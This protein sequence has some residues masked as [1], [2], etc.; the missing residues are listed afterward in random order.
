MKF[1]T[2]RIL[3]PLSFLLILS[4]TAFSQTYNKDLARESAF[5]DSITGAKITR[6]DI[7]P[8]A[9]KLKMT[10][11]V[12]AFTLALWQNDALI[13]TYPV[14]VGMKEYPIF[15]GK[16]D[17]SEIIYNPPWIPPDSDWVKPE[18]R[19]KIIKPDDPGNPLGK[20]K[21]PLGL[22]YLLHQAK[23]K[24]DLGSLVSHGCVRVMLNDL[25]DL[26]DKYIAAYSLDVL[27]KSLETAKS[28]KKTFVITIPKATP[29]EVT[30]DT[31]V[32]RGGELL[33]FPDIYGYKPDTKSEV[34][35]ELKLNKISTAKINDAALEKL[36][37]KAKGKTKVV[38]SVKNLKAG[39]LNLAKTLPV[40]RPR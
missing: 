9:G 15:I 2:R 38:I 36:V 25:Y 8:G 12:P 32:V 5:S 24:Q 30:Y 35:N 22:G 16:R 27:P 28:T 29:I 37:K 7:K 20:V 13:S 1:V 11:N 40:L 39:K 34:L 18:M 19:G 17:F 3:I 4:I 31:A 26:T 10:L 23:G 33:I 21:F 14:G 6:A